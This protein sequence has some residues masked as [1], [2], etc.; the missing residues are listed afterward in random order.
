MFYLQVSISINGL[1][2]TSRLCS[3]RISKNDKLTF[4]PSE[5]TCKILGLFNTFDARISVQ[6]NQS[7]LT[8]S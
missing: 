2:S 6:A 1:S 8:F 4:G 5:K 7:L 3:S